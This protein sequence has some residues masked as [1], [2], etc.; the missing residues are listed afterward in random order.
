MEDFASSPLALA[1]RLVLALGARAARFPAAMLLV[2]ALLGVA[3]AA[4]Y[5]VAR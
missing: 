5:M 3:A 1:G 2:L 4:G